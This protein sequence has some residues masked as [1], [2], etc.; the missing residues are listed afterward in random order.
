MAQSLIERRSALLA[1]ARDLL[2]AD[3]EKMDKETYARVEGLMEEHDAVDAEIKAA[4]KAGSLMDRVRGADL[5][6]KATE[7]TPAD[8][9]AATL[10]DHFVKHAGDVLRRQSN[11]AQMQSATPEYETRAADDPFL[12]PNAEGSEVAHLAPWTTEFRRSIVNAKRDKLVIADL[13]GAATVA[14]QTQ[15]ISYLVEKLPLVAEGGAATVAEGA[16]KPYVRFNNFEIESE[17]LTKIAALT[18]ITDETAADLTFVRSWIN[19]RLIYE[20]SVVEEEQLLKGDGTGSNLTGLLNRE[21][22]QQYDIAGDL[23]D[24]LF[25]ASQKVPEFTGL[26]ADALVVNTADF[27][28]IRLAKDGNGQYFAGGPFTAGQYGNGG[29]TLNPAPWGLRTV[30]TPAI[31]RGTYVLGAFRQGSTVLRKNGLRV[32]STNS[33]VDDF[34]QNLITLRA[35]ERLGLMVERP[36][37]FVTGSLAGSEIPGVPAPADSAAAA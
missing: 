21:G 14:A 1:E 5:G 2:P 16:R 18:K 11:G 10:G 4:E 20:L 35:E 13:M 25:L 28:R 7:D 3:G 6:E 26:T 8:H 33:N 30:D 23:F 32:D 24:G 22:L 34:E 31:A 36:A 19:D 37:A 17:K 12:T 29:L 27:V 15:T 9:A